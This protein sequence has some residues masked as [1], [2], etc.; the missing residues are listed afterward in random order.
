MIENHP[1]DAFITKD[2]YASEH[3]NTWFLRAKDQINRGE[4]PGDTQNIASGGAIQLSG[5]VTGLLIRV[6]SSTAANVDITQIEAGFDGQVITAE[7]M[8]A[9]KTVTIKSGGN[10]KLAGAAD[11]ILGLNDVITFHFNASKAVWIE[12]TRSTN[13]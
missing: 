3:F 4:D 5:E 12:N 10:V 6:Q 8:D 9:T 1:Q 11:F 13:G 7:G 2:S